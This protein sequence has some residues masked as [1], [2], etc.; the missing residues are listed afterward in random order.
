M[1]C[2]NVILF[3]GAYCARCILRKRYSLYHVCVCGRGH[4]RY[5]QRDE[6]RAHSS[7]PKPQSN[8]GT[9]M[10]QQHRLLVLCGIHLVHKKTGC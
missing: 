10:W 6:T 3:V 9:D 8:F 2:T 4:F 5:I 7:F 1:V